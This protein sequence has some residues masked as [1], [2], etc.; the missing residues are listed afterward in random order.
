MGRPGVVGRAVKRVEYPAKPRGRPIA[1]RS[2]EFLCQDVVIRKALG[3]NLPAHTLACQIDFG[4]E[5][6][7]SFLVDPETR[8][9]PRVLD[10]AGLQNDFDG[11]CQ[12]GR[13]R[14]C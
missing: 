12:V 13:I 10:V 7:A 8:F 5:V 9:L 14:Q 3:Q 6:D 1:G 4:N 11:R 2:A